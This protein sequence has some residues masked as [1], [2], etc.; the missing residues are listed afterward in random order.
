MTTAPTLPFV[1]VEEYLNSS[2]LPDMEYVEGA[3][4]GRSLPTYAHSV[5]QLIVGGHLRNCRKQFHFGVA[6]ECRVELVKRSRYRIPDLLLAS[7]PVNGADKALKT[8]PLA[9]I[10]IWSPDDK[11]P[12]QMARFQEY[13]NRGVRQIIV[14]DPEHFSAFRY[15]DN[16]LSQGDIEHIELPDGQ[17]VPFSSLELLNELREE[18]ARR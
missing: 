17:K 12:Q 16:A 14:L 15:N 7:L 1:P 8:A 2:W 5:L 10:E 6:S 4:V 11:M 18:L 9:V 3:L 13:W